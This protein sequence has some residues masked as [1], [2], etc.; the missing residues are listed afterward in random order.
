MAIWNLLE[1]CLSHYKMGW[2][3]HVVF[4]LLKIFLSS[5][6]FPLIHLR[7]IHLTKWRWP[8]NNDQNR[9]SWLKSW[10]R[11]TLTFEHDWKYNQ[12]SVIFTRACSLLWSFGQVPTLT[13]IIVNFIQSNSNQFLVILI[14]SI[15]L[16][17]FILISPWCKKVNFVETLIVIGH[18]T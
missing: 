14:W 18:S 2:K 16:A 12:F 6:Y 3:F 11:R 4:R 5:N 7:V 10:Q 13:F 9:W 1:L 15:E 17:S 8:N